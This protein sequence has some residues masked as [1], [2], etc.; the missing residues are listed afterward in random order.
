VG[1]T[2]DL[3]PRKIK[4]QRG[5]DRKWNAVRAAV[6]EVWMRKDIDGLDHRIEGLKRSLASAILINIQYVQQ[7]VFIP[8]SLLSFDQGVFR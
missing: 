2:E 8:L 5:I 4:R 1:D 6:R 3:K 7:S